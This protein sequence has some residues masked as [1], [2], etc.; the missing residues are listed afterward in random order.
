MNLRS[1]LA[2]RIH[3]NDIHELTF[4]TQGEENNDK[5]AKL[6]KLLFDKDKRVADNAAW[7]FTHFNSRNSQWL[8]DKH[9]ELIDETMSTT[10]DT[11]RRLLMSI[12]LRQPFTKERVR[13]DFLDFCLSR[14]LSVKEPVGIKA[15]C[16]KLSYEQCKHFPELKLELKAALEIMEPEFMS[17]G[18]RSV[19]K[20]ILKMI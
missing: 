13:I 9:D 17:T 11:K 6:Y 15:L 14:M 4:L 8:Y 10:S 5:K 19:R 3:E 1:K 20:N 18:L 7:V 2:N 16:I 12:L